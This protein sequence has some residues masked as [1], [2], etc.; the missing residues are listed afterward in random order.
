M[1]LSKRE[2]MIGAAAVTALLCMAQIKD[3]YMPV[4]AE[5]LAG[6]YSE[7]NEWIPTAENLK[8]KALE[9]RLTPEEL[10]IPGPKLILS[11]EDEDRLLKIAMAEAEGEDTTGKALVM[12]VV[13][14][15]TKSDKFPATIKEVIEQPG[16]FEPVANGRYYS[17]QPNED[18]YL[19]L[20]SLYMMWDCSEG[21]TYFAA[22]GCTDWHDAHLIRLFAHGGHV[23]Y[24][25]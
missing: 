23:F 8:W 4:K 13:M 24:K 9:E 25:E 15:R 17:A 22:E 7:S 20:Q 18:C 10:Q 6:L 14:N 12:L 5:S 16:Q 11:E 3:T 1:G 19:A 2:V 21:A